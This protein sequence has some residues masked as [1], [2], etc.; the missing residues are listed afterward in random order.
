MSAVASIMLGNDLT[1]G[2]GDSFSAGEVRN[3]YSITVTMAVPG[4]FLCSS[5]CIYQ[6]LSRLSL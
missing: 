4:L 2:E 3:K 6:I 1:M 5:D